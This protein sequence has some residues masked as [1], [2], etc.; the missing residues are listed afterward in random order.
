MLRLV[1]LVRTD[2][3]EERI[4]TII[5]TILSSETSVLTGA[6]RPNVSED[7]I[8]QNHRREN[9]KSYKWN[10][11]CILESTLSQILTECCTNG[12]GSVESEEIGLWCITLR[13]ARFAV[14][15][16]IADR[17]SIFDFIILNSFLKF[18][19]LDCWLEFWLNVSPPFVS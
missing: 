12:Q 2:V 18:S 7:C 14:S 6:T 5:K 8:L 13:I 4:A 10:T 9:L 16:D 1:A 3:S 15:S 17:W 19:S 11:I